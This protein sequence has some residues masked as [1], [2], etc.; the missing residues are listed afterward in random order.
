MILCW[1]NG[2]HKGI[3]L[4]ECREV[5][6]YS[7]RFKIVQIGGQN[8]ASLT[9]GAEP[10]T[11]VRPAQ[12]VAGEAAPA[13][14]LTGRGPEG[15]L[16]GNEVVIMLVRPAVWYLLG[17]S[18]RFSAVVAL[19]AVW[20]GPRLTA[21]HWLTMQTV[22]SL[23]AI[24]IMVRLGYAVMDWL[25]HWYMLTNCRIITIKG[26]R[27]PVFYQV[28]LSKI[29]DV[30]LMRSPIERILGVG[31]IGFSTESQ[32]NPDSLWH[33]VAHPQRVHRQILR[34]MQDRRK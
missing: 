2:R 27:R 18:L 3:R 16:H 15:L 14:V 33:W 26:V 5:N 4:C 30:H 8:A 17:G 1:L 13:A 11:G 23:V 31:T 22:L 32:I 6:I 20:L 24:L 19:L 10:A 25:S 7:M 9:A 34:T 28:S 12:P 21:A 29:C